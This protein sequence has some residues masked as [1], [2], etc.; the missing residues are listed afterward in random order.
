MREHSTVNFRAKTLFACTAKVVSS[1]RD[2]CGGIPSADRA[3]AP[4]RHTHA[5]NGCWQLFI[6]RPGNQF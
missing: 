2:A 3:V 5:A 6:S 1:V 4:A